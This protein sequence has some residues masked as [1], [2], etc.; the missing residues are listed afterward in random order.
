MLA[1]PSLLLVLVT[2]VRAGLLGGLWGSVDDRMH[3]QVHRRAPSLAASIRRPVSRPVFAYGPRERQPD[4]EHQ[5]PRAQAQTRRNP[6]Q[7]ARV[8]SRVLLAAATQDPFQ[9]QACLE[10]TYCYQ[11]LLTRCPAHSNSQNRSDTVDDCLC[12]A[13]FFQNA[14]L[15]AGGACLPCPPNLFCPGGGEAV[16]CHEHSR[17]ELGSYAR[18][19]CICD[20]G[21]SQDAESCT[22]CAVGTHKA[23]GGSMACAGCAEGTYAP[24]TATVACAPCPANTVSGAGSWELAACV[25]REGAYGAPGS[26][27]ALCAE[28]FYAHQRNLSGCVPC[29]SDSYLPATGSTSPGDCIACPAD[30]AVFANAIAT[31]NGVGTALGLCVCMPGFE[32]VAE[33][34]RACGAGAHKPAP[35]NHPCVACAPDTFASPDSTACTPCALH[36]SSDAGS[37][38]AFNCTCDP[39]YAALAAGEAY[40]DARSLAIDECVAC[41]AGSFK[42]HLRNAACERCAPGFYQLA[43]ASTA[44]DECAADRFVHADGACVPCGAH[45]EAPARSAAAAACTCAAGYARAALALRGLAVGHE[46]NGDGDG[47]GDPDCRACP[48][49]FFR[50]V[51]DSDLTCRACPAGHVAPGA[52]NAAPDDCVPCGV[53]AY[54]AATVNGSFC[55]QCPQHANSSELSVGIDSC[56]CAAGFF[57]AGESWEAGPTVEHAEAL[58]AGLLCEACASGMFKAAPGNQACALC[59]EGTTGASEATLRV[60]E[61]SCAPCS[62]NTYSILQY[63]PDARAAVFECVACPDNALSDASSTSVGNCTCASGFSFAATGSPCEACAP[64]SFKREAANTRCSHCE[65]GAYAFGAASACTPCPANTTTAHAGAENSSACVCRPGYVLASDAP[66]DR[67]GSCALCA[68]GSFSEGLGAAACD[69]CGSHAFLSLLAAPGVRA[70]EACPARSRAGSR[71]LGVSGCVPFA[72]LLRASTNRTT[73]VELEMAV[74]CSPQTVASQ[75]GPLQSAIAALASAG[76]GCAVA[77]SDVIVTR[78]SAAGPAGS[79]RRLLSDG[80]LVGVAILVPSAEAGSE[81]VQGGALSVDSV[82]ASL[83]LLQ[84]TAITAGPTLL[85]DADFFVACPADSYCPDQSTVIRCPPNSSAPVG[86]AQESNCTCVPGLFGA[87]RNCSVCRPDFFCPGAT[88]EPYPCIANSSTRGRAAADDPEDCEC[89]AGLYRAYADDS[90]SGSECRV[91]PENSFCY[92]E[93][94]VLCPANSSAPRGAQSVEACECHAGMELQQSQGTPDCPSGVCSEC[95][96]C[97]SSSVC[98][99]G[100]LVEHC[101]QNATSVNMACRC[102]AG[103]YCSE[104]HSTFGFGPSCSPE[105]N[106]SETLCLACARAHYCD[107]IAE[108]ACGAGE[109]ALERSSDSSACRCRPGY[110]RIAP[111]QCAVCGFGFV[112]PGGMPDQPPFPQ[113]PYAPAA[114]SPASVRM[115]LH[116]NEARM[117]APLF[118]PHLVTLA[119]DTTD[120]SLAVCGP[121][122]FR[123]ARVDSCKLCP[124][125]FWCPPEDEN[126][127]LPNVIACL[128]NEAT[129]EAGSISAEECYCAAGFKINDQEDVS[130]CVACEAGERCQAGEVVEAQCHAMKRVPNADHS[131]CVCAVGHG[132]YALE[133]L[134]C[135]PGSSKIFIG[136]VP[137]AFCAV[138]EYI[139]DAHGPCL[140]CPARSNSRPGSTFCTC[141][142]PYTWNAGQCGL[143]EDDFYWASLATPA[144]WT[145]NVG[146]GAPP[147]QCLPCPVN[148]FGNSSAA[149]PL[150]LA[151][152]TC[153]GGSSALPRLP[154]NASLGAENA[155]AVNHLLACVP[156]DAGEFE[157]DGVCRTCPTNSSSLPGSVGLRGCLCARSLPSDACLAPRVDASCAGACADTPGACDACQP[158]FHKSAFST[159]GNSD[160]CS[161]C[162][163]GAFQDSWA[164][165]ECQTCPAHRTTVLPGRQSLADCKCVPGWTQALAGTVECTACV[166]GYFKENTGDEPCDVCGVGRYQPA[167][168]S[169]SCYGCA[170]ATVSLDAFVQAVALEGGN[171]THDIHPALESNRTHD[172]NSVSVLQCVCSVGNEPQPD[173][174]TK[175]CQSC[176]IGSY[177]PNVGLQACFYCGRQ[178]IPDIGGHGVYRYG[179]ESFPVVDFQHCI[180]CPPSSGQEPAIVGPSSIMDG[181]DKCKCF[182]GHE[183]R[184]MFGCSICRPY[185]HQPQYSDADCEFCQAGHFFVARQYLCQLCDL[186]DEDN[187]SPH[188]AR[189]A[190]SINLRCNRVL[191]TRALPARR[192]APLCAACAPLRAADRWRVAVTPGPSTRTTAY[193]DRATSAWWKTSRPVRNANRASSTQTSLRE[194]AVHVR[195]TRTSRCLQHC[196]AYRAPATLEH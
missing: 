113:A 158:G 82:N 53:A 42:E 182:P 105:S 9:C 186:R 194:R 184:T 76:C 135:P 26:E 160:A 176:R 40:A 41:A 84:I 128:E 134:L 3:L 138:D 31:P 64:G 89:D 119:A 125:N 192:C 24:A 144:R 148:S 122:Y 100:G 37:A 13:G 44:C 124:Q 79:A 20:A 98:H 61:S 129:E 132:E 187:H 196:S 17:S 133:C 86:S 70:C 103:M 181:V 141:Q 154:S 102:A 185:M 180:P 90:F 29:P 110:Y 117:A 156:C 55:R 46:D 62:P 111:A 99:R 16:A 38:S 95:V 18:A 78:V 94:R 190:N 171:G 143:C 27:A 179:N 73:R 169:T 136:D 21:Y 56:L 65:V 63:S 120:I 50:S 109:D 172:E 195:R 87:A 10:G 146:F 19:Q 25:A 97:T 130:R 118:D 23:L 121:G 161:E 35:G 66:V 77:S 151:H 137:C 140:P 74:A 147:G 126:S 112:C 88:A 189:V 75:Q 60:D 49:G 175:R 57:R 4:R 47:D 123:T 6:E 71:A 1:K 183:Q 165:A 101:V 68:P 92:G 167:S 139:V 59:P 164:A 96:Q 177:K 7:S 155:S 131:K 145:A 2:V 104:P 142:A 152:C 163:V 8:S 188:Q 116:G 157:D 83:P 81:L 15:S 34:C 91:C 22:A 72:G 85:T 58:E 107:G 43:S 159:P 150:G 153:E 174:D 170:D 36:S 115:L 45:E 39:G 149:M 168:N 28:G 54:V 11:N 162:I 48:P 14:S 108:T 52:A 67:G 178:D 93:A 5:P 191:A 69:D 12:K 51:E 127:A 30:S 114:V 80:S 193:A 106:V 166:P 32:R 173:G 33:R